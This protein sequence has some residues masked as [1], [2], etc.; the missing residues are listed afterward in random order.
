MRYKSSD[1]LKQHLKKI[2]FGY[3]ADFDETIITSTIVV[4]TSQIRGSRPIDFRLKIDGEI[5]PLYV[6]TGLVVEIILETSWNLDMHSRTTW[7]DVFNLVSFQVRVE[8]KPLRE[9]LRRFHGTRHVVDTLA[10]NAKKGPHNHIESFRGT[11]LGDVC[12][13][14]REAPVATLAVSQ[15]RAYATRYGSLK[16]YDLVLCGSW[17]ELE[18]LHQHEHL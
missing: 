4:R 2:S 16:T 9:Y 5:L 14:I 12:L 13:Y 3:F 8:A 18:S 7:L 15:W 17:L 11:N 1:E 6:G 10:R